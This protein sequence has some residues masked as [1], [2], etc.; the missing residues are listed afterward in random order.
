MNIFILHRNPKKSAKM[1]C[2]K[3][4]VKMILESAQMLCTAHW[5]RGSE[6]PY[7]PTHKNHPCN[8][9]VRKSYGN[10]NWLLRHAL[11]IAKEY[12]RRYKRTHRVLEILKWCKK[13]KPKLKSRKRTEFVQAMPDKYKNK[14]AVKAYQDYYLKEKLRFCKWNHSKKPKFVRDYEEKK[15]NSK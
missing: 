1:L 11:A 14:N 9:W 5:M 10:Y 13:N 7:K 6:A 2:D 8:K 12:K 3:H 15:K 4:I